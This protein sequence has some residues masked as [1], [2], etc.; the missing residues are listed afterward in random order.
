MRDIVLMMQ[1]SRWRWRPFI[2]RGGD[3]YF[4]IEWFCVKFSLWKSFEASHGE[5]EARQKDGKIEV[6]GFLKMVSEYKR[7][8]RRIKRQITKEEE[9]L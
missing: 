5:W 2:L 6:S 3:C 4:Y 8:I 9:G 1:C 7:K